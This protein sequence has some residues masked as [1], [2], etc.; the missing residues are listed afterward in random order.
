[1]I[2]L[3]AVIAGVFLGSTLYAADLLQIYRDA[4]A[5]DPQYAAALAQ[6]QA[7]QEVVPQARAQLLPFVNLT[8]G[9]DR[10][11]TDVRVRG[12]SVLRG[13]QATFSTDEITLAVTQPLFRWQSVVQLRQ[14]EVQLT[15]NAAQL[16]VATQDLVLRVSQAYF[17]VLG[18][19]DTLAFVRAQKTAINEQLAQAKRNFE[20]GTATIVDTHEAQARF[21]LATSQEIAAQNELEIRKRALQQIIG[22]PPPELAPLAEDFRLVGPI[23]GEMDNWV[24]VSQKGALPVIIQEAALDIATKEIERQ[25]AGHYPTLDAVASI[26]ETSSTGSATF[27]SGND[28]TSKVVGLQ[29]AWPIYQGGLI[30]SRVREAAANQDR[31]RSLLVDAQR[32]AALQTR[33]SFLNVTNGIAQ[34]EALKAALASSQ[35]SLESTTTGLEVGVRTQVDVLNAQQQLFSARRDLAL[36]RYNAI[37]NLLR[38][39]AA[40][41][42][43]EDSDVLEVNRW[44][45]GD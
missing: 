43:L 3:A 5:Q 9:I 34:V 25:R 11:E 19:Q 7:G 18:A 8:A 6:Y 24:E 14:A 20:V 32:T 37:L 2:R 28:T 1:M 36:A 16:Q 41:G 42:Q 10:N 38:L 44:L 23:P 40:V 31:A 26:A 12:A 21:D 45:A 33:Q 13:G 17:D 30:N 22:Y 15:Q 4:V 27:G 39:E 29:L 35:L